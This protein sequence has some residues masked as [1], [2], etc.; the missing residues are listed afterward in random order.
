ML[1][2]VPSDDE[3]PVEVVQE[4]KNTSAVNFDDVKIEHVHPNSDSAVVPN[5]LSTTLD[6]SLPLLVFY[7][8]F[9]VHTDCQTTTCLCLYVYMYVPPPCFLNL[10]P[11]S[12]LYFVPPLYFYLTVSLCLSFS[13]FKIIGL[14]WINRCLFTHR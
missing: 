12:F 2:S 4:N 7:F 1:D 8:I 14:L 10:F 5:A 6:M 9:F 11:F 3:E 13:T